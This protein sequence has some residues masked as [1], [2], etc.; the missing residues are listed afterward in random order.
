MNVLMTDDV[1]EGGKCVNRGVPR[2]VSPSKFMRELRP[3]YYSDT[4]E[5]TSYFLSASTLEYH[6]DSI[7]SRNQ[8]HDFEI[9]CRKLCE[10]TICPNLRPQ[11]GPDGG[12][13]S[14]ADTETYPVAEEISGLTYV[15]DANGGSER[16]A[17]A[18]S[19][20][21]TWADKVRKDVSGIA[22]TGRPYSRIICVTSRF[23]KA[24]DRA[25]VE[26]ELS[27]KYG[28]PVTVHDRSWIVKEVIE[29][30]RIDL[31]VNYLNVG[32]P[33]TDPLRLGP[34]DYSRFQ[35]LRDAERTIEDPEAFRGMERQRATEALVAAKL[36]RGLERPRVETDGR[37]ARAIRLADAD[38]TY[39]QKLE[40][41]YEQIWTA[42]WWFDDFG[43]LNASYD[44]FESRAL[45]SDHAKNLEFLGN[46]N[47]LLV[48]A[49]IHGHMTHEECRLDERTAKLE[50]ALEA[51]AQ[52]LDRPN[53]GLEAQTA[54]TRIA[55][56]R[57][58]VAR[59]RDALPA[60]WQ[61]FSA[62]LEKA[63]GLGE[64]DADSLVSFI[65]VAGQA[66][67]NDPAY[68]DLVEKLADFV[69]SRK[70]E[71]EG[72]LILLKRAR[73]LDFADRFDMI[74]W[75]GKAAIGLTKREYAE[76]LIEAVQLLMLAYRSAGLPWAARASCVFAASSIIIE[77]EGDSE[78]SVSIVPTMKIWA[79]NALERCH[80]PDFLFAI[81]LLNGFVAGL[82]LTE[83][84]KAKV[85][86]DIRE[87]DAAVGCFFL[88]LEEPALRRLERVPDILEA[89]GLFLA[90]TALLYTLGYANVLREDGS[91]PK[92]EK[93]EDVKRM[94][95]MLK[96]Q[97]V[98]ESLQGP[99]ILNDEG[100]QTLATMILGMRV[101]VEIDGSG[102][103]LIAE[104]ILGSL[105]AFFATVIEH[106][107]IPHTELFRITIN[108]S[109]QAKE[110]VIE[111]H[112]F[113][114][115][116]TITWPSGLSVTRFDQQHEV[117]K[118][119]FVVAGHVLGA[120]C[121]IKDAK[122]LVE[123]LYA[124]EAVHQRMTIAVTP[125]S[126]S[127]VAS[128]S[129]ASLSDWQEV[130]RRSYPLRDQRPELSVTLIR[131]SKNPD[132]SNNA[133]DETFEI[134]NHSRMTVRSVIDVHAWD[135]AVWRGCGYLQI[136]YARPPYLALLFEN[137]AAARKIFERWRARFGDEDGNEEIAFSIIR[138]LPNTN[139]HHYCVQVTSKHP[140]V[141]SNT[142]KRPFVT[143]TRSMT[144]EPANSEN[145]DMFLA[146]YERSAAYY[147]FPAVGTTNPEFLFDL[148]ILKRSL[149][150]KTAAEVGEHDIE[151][152]A[153]RIRGL[154]FA[155]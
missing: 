111:T 77:G 64:F 107:V 24:K 37:Y 80:L 139:P 16:W 34:T 59:D 12:G 108:Q 127:R 136:G 79:W 56:N 41:R 103:I 63:G 123:K 97:P 62:I 36:S 116:S 53:N 149:T 91:L 48:N 145:L 19:A 126:Y 120:A 14:K 148:T 50:Q 118:F 140:A 93:D 101:E 102:S 57:A 71:A 129:F 112:E 32:E 121:V 72:A 110:P 67:G 122:S 133:D 83:E 96:N 117:G 109:D 81:Q 119:L 128:R 105:E 106:R 31:A 151:S 78:L 28:I 69:G 4:Q 115:L 30:E 68:N 135:A 29:N 60:V 146:E 65:E 58:M 147:L 73:K 84:S 130:V 98:A 75:L 6:L 2:G 55:L 8:T 25:R 20:K 15:G 33:V 131:E 138:N 74:R 44:D 1:A 142:S 143:A 26:D 22:E 9:F 144:M 39:R 46:L 104:S 11:T 49:V 70:S 90:R 89:L 86:D 47:Q 99:L 27:K 35:E 13:D 125:N 87:L 132:E 43:F 45:K 38:G 153:L 134:K 113:D 40:A 95:S 82:P 114:M 154:K 18:F 137:A 150:V 100:P 155:S 52:N 141:S 61:G 17:F 3:Q 5:R 42:F 76:Q 21:A 51:I 66:A 152:F 124:D 88:N 7:T 85:R 54:L 94:L 23:A 92:G 10:R